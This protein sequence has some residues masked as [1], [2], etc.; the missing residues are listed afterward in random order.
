MNYGWIYKPSSDTTVCN[1]C[2][3]TNYGWLYKPSSD[4]RGCNTSKH[5]TGMMIDEFY[6]Y[7]MLVCNIYRQ[8]DEYDG[9]Q[10]TLIWFKRIRWWWWMTLQT[11]IWYVLAC[12]ICRQ[13][14]DGWLN[15]QSFDYSV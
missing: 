4:T 2:R 11:F 5:Y 13:I 15:K 8:N 10:Q 12:K 1:V 7:L 9:D 14:D 3:Q 6:V